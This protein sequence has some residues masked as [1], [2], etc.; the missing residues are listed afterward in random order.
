[1][2]T[3]FLSPCTKMKMKIIVTLSKRYNPLQ[4]GVKADVRTRQRFNNTHYPYRIVTP[5]MT[6]YCNNGQG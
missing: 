4:Y 3:K 5:L 6:C 2:E 1:M